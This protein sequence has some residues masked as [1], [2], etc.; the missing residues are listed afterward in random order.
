MNSGFLILFNT[1]LKYMCYNAIKG[2]IMKQYKVE[3]YLPKEALDKI[4]E[5]LYKVGLGKVGNY[6]CC[7]SWYEINSSWR[8]QE[9]QIHI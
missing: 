7:L 3:T 8:P 1:N 4:K 6:D 2:V 9:G 5:G